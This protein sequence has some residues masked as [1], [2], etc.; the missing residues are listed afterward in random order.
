MHYSSQCQQLLKKMVTVPMNSSVARNDAK[1]WY[2]T[3]LTWRMLDRLATSTSMSSHAG[4]KRFWILLIPWGMQ[5][6][7]GARSFPSSWEMGPSQ[8]HFSGKQRG[9]S[10]IL[11]VLTHAVRLSKSWIFKMTEQLDG[12]SDRA[13]IVCWVS[14]NLQPFSIIED[15]GFQS[16]MRTGFPGGC[17]LPLHWTVAWDVH[18]VFAHTCGQIAKMLQVSWSTVQ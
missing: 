17:Y 14:E 18:L 9:K 12:P 3:S 10:H 2:G 16:L 6:R 5:V 7:S 8:W 1:A 11:T 15:R 4:V 13:E